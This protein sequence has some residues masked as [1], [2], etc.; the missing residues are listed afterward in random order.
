MQTCALDGIIQGLPTRSATDLASRRSCPVRP[1]YC[2]FLSKLSRQGDSTEQDYILDHL[3]SNVPAHLP[4][5]DLFLKNSR[6][7]CNLAVAE[8]Q[9]AGSFFAAPIPMGS[10]SSIRF[11]ERLCKSPVWT[12]TKAENPPI[13]CQHLPNKEVELKLP[14]TSFS[15]GYLGQFEC[16]I[17]AV[18]GQTFILR[19]HFRFF[20]MSWGLWAIW[21]L[22]SF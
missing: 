21:A 5:T 8:V 15:K 17:P 20:V 6:D 18:L 13:K 4:Y 2:I 10:S 1:C 3:A 9:V 11:V 22:Q 16:Y 14:Q 12:S 7:A 19:C